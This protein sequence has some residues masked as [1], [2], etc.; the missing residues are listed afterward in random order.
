MDKG[1][2][3]GKGNHL[4]VRGNQ[5]AMESG[6]LYPR[7]GLESRIQRIRLEQHTF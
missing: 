7:I 4:L 2:I 6:A 5:I 3:C 1:I